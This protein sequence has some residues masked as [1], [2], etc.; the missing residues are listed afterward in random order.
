MRALGKT[1]IWRK[2][3]KREM[4]RKGEKGANRENKKTTAKT[5]G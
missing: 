1:Y 2:K 4:E 5:E 3:T